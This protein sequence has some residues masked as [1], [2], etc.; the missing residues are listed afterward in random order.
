[1][2]FDKS[3]YYGS[4][5]Y[6]NKRINERRGDEGEGVDTIRL[7]RRLNLKNLV[8]IHDHAR[9]LYKMMRYD[10]LPHVSLSFYH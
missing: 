5:N 4:V 2:E 7:G 9:P 8:Y 10:W 3:W 1:M 6:R